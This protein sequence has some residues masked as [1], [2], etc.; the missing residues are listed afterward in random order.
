MTIK[1]GLSQKEEM[2]SLTKYLTAKR[3]S[4]RVVTFMMWRGPG[5]GEG[6]I[7]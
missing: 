1:V 6:G 7:V 4:S 2:R 3:V 5:G